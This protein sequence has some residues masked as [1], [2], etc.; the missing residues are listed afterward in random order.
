MCGRSSGCRGP[1]T[2]VIPVLPRHFSLRAVGVNLE[3][4]NI[5]DQEIMAF[6]Y[7]ALLLL[8]NSSLAVDAFVV[9]GWVE[10]W[11]YENMTDVEPGTWQHN[12]IH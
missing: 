7:Y 4:L 10:E 2:P 3:H 6:W 5:K 9:A 8:S 12:K 11:E 1:H